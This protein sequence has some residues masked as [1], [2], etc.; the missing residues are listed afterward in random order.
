MTCV[1]LGDTDNSSDRI[2]KAFV[3]LQF[4]EADPKLIDKYIVD[5]VMLYVMGENKTA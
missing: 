4:R 1:V 2:E 5:Y 3:F